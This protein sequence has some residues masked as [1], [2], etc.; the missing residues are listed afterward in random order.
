MTLLLNSDRGKALC[1][2]AFS[3]TS[4]AKPY[5]QWHVEK[6]IQNLP[7]VLSRDWKLQPGLEVK[8]GSFLLKNRIYV[9][10]QLLLSLEDLSGELLRQT[11]VLTHSWPQWDANSWMSFFVWRAWGT[12]DKNLSKCMC[13]LDLRNVSNLVSTQA[14]Q[15]FFHKCHLMACYLIPFHCV[16]QRGFNG[17]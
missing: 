8:D 4:T 16:I 7:G 1:G 15:W 6:A 13:F 5:F 14:Y 3:T 12:T 10:S 9:F 2:S 11:T 17:K